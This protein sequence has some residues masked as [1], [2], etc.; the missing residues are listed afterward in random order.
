M[1]RALVVVL[2]FFAT[3][4]AVVLLRTP[5]RYEPEIWQPGSIAEA[6]AWGRSTQTVA[7]IK[8]IHP[9]LRNPESLELGVDGLV[10]TGTSDGRIWR[11]DPAHPDTAATLLGQVGAQPLGVWPAD[12]GAV[13]IAATDLGLLRL[14]NGKVERMLSEVD[15]EPFDFAN[16]LE[17]LP[18]GRIVISQASTKYKMANH[19]WDIMEAAANGR[20]VLYDP[21]SKSARTLVD[22]VAF[23]NGVAV[24]EDGNA[25]LFASSTRHRI[26]RYWL[27]GPKAGQR[28][29]FLENLPGYPDNLTVD[30]SGLHWIALASPRVGFMDILMQRFVFARQLFGA[31]PREWL[32]TGDVTWALA[33]NGEG[34]VAHSVRA[35]STGFGVITSALRVGDRL[36]LG[37]VHG[38]GIGVI[39]LATPS[40]ADAAQASG[41]GR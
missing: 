2:V 28:E 30:S 25:V 11:F 1:K 9:Q 26:D 16:N 34:R 7:A 10:Y 15:G 3:V 13:W 12:D 8:T 41:Q 21:T 14:H 36:L 6:N 23:A 29:A 33:V 37:R 35:E 22:G 32:P 38:E 27:S 24:V 17:S 39:D 19:G 40:A 4:V 5:S 18:D 31:L 20:I